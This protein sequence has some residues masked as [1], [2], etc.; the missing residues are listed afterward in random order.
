MKEQS[1][2]LEGRRFSIAEGLSQHRGAS[3]TVR[4]Y[5]Y[6][7]DGVG[8]PSLL[9]KEILMFQKVQAKKSRYRHPLLPH[10]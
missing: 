7:V 8:F 6:E 5:T 1:F 4:K 2:Q 10:N 9:I 3:V